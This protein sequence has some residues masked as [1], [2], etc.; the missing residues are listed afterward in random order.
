MPLLR[1]E[2][3]V[4]GKPTRAIMYICG[5]GQFELHINGQKI[6]E[7][8]LQ[9]GWTD[10]RRT[11]LYTAYDVA[12]FLKLGRNAIGVMLGNGMYNVTPGRFSKFH[13][14]FGSPQLIA[15][16][17]IEY[18]DGTTQ[19]ICSDETWKF[20]SGPITFSCIYGGE[21][22]DAQLE[23]PGWDQPDFYD[24][25]WTNAAIM[26]G[27]R[28]QRAAQPD[29]PCPSASITSSSRSKSRRCPT[30]ITFTILARTAQSFPRSPSAVPPARS[31]SSLP[32]KSSATTAASPSDPPHPA[33][34]ERG[35]LTP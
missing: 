10:Y 2:F 18:P 8:F 19:R 30:A 7:D 33:A 20:A 26:N 3:A 34:A 6:S 27:P 25:A 5:L 35:M 28:R 22:Y 29:P 17:L 16:L 15:Q 4:S 1:K 13:G 24:A 9:P 31:S 23:Q 11:C 14:S 21:D 32:A 12:P